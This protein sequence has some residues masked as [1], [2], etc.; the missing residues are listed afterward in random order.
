[1][2]GPGG[3]IV[4]LCLCHRATVVPSGDEHGIR[5]KA[6]C[7][8]LD[9]RSQHRCGRCPRPRRRV[10]Q[11]GRSRRFS[12]RQHPRARGPGQTRGGSPYGRFARS[13]V[14]RWHATPR[15]PDRRVRQ[16]A[17]GPAGCR[18]R[19]PPGPCPS[20]AAWRCAFSRARALLRSWSTDLCRG[21][22]VRPVVANRL[23][24]PATRTLPVGSSVR[25]WLKRPML[26]EPVADH[27]PVAGS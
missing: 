20:G 8:M 19:R 27:V 21:R 18:G 13:R 14:P 26:I 11:L 15:S 5:T 1:M 22:R 25:V 17:D 16:L 2:P 7:R 4:E 12:R 10:I 6:G 3:W 23:R 9:S 24:P